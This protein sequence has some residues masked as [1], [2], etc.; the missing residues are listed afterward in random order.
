[1]PRVTIKD[2]AERVGLSIATVSAVLGSK[3]HCYA[4]EKTK[5]LIK[6]T[7]SE[8]G[9][10]PNIVARS[11]KDGRT[12]TIGLLEA[13][14]QNEVKRDEIIELSN[15]FRQR[16][17]FLYIEYFKGEAASL[18]EICADLQ[19]RGVDGFI[20][21]GILDEPTYQST[22]SMNTPTVYIYTHRDFYDPKHVILTDHFQGASLALEY[23][24]ELGH[25]HICQFGFDG[26]EITKDSDPRTVAYFSFA[27]RYA[28]KADD[29]YVQVRPEQ[30]TRDFVAEFLKS[31]PN[32]TAIFCYNDLIAM[33]LIQCC[34]QLGIKVPEDL[35]VI[36]FDD[37]I[38]ARYTTPALT[39]IH[40]PIKEASAAAF[41]MMI[42]MLE[43]ENLQPDQ[44]PQETLVIR[45]SVAVPRKRRKLVF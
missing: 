11:L 25:R 29:S 31:H 16:G 26:K 7:A 6:T 22:V 24:L 10:R 36:G 40:Q 4:S 43:G 14:L 1:M 38:S 2:I 32:C 37:I 19:C 3:K 20:I 5:A 34:S 42:N 12:H 44:N 41:Q 39:T 9:Y 15:L 28:C 21:S 27:D 8:M 35:S 23:L 17:Y 45:E 30:I 13:A 18:Q 33:Q